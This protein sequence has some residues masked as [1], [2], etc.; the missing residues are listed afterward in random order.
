MNMEQWALLASEKPGAY[1]LAKIK[2]RVWAR[3]RQGRGNGSL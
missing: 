2:C 1:G 3:G